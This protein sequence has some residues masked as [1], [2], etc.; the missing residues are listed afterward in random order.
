[1]TATLNGRACSEARVTIPRYGVWSGWCTLTDAPPVPDTP[2]GLSLVV[3][4]LTMRCTAVR[5]ADRAGLRSVEIV[6]GYGG[7]DR[8]VRPQ[9]FPADNLVG[10]AAYVSDLATQAG[11]HIQLDV[12]DRKLGP[13]AVRLGGDASGAM[14]T[15]ACAMPAGADII[16]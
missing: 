2:G 16:P 9:G 4:G 1:M 10:L 8:T 14:L 5:Q 6:G 7:W 11:E 3:A 12:P 15:Q 13:L